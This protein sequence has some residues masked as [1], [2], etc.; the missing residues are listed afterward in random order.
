MARWMLV[1]LM[2]LLGFGQAFA[3]AENSLQIESV[4]PGAIVAIDRIVNDGK[5]IISVSDAG[6]QPVLGLGVADF[7][8]TQDGRKANIIS[9]ES[10]EQNLDVPR[11]IVLVLDNSF[12]MQERNAVKPILAAMDELLKIV[13]PIDQVSLVVF[14]DRETRKVGGRNLHVQILQSSSPSELKGFVKQAY[15]G[16]LTS[17]T[18]LHEGMLAGLD[19]VSRMPEGEPKFMVVFSD[20]E[21]LNSDVSADEVIQASSG[22]KRFAGYAIDYMPGPGVDPLL[23]AFVNRS[24]GQAWKARAESNLV[25]I[26]QAVASRLQY[27]YV[28]SYLFPTLGSLAVA[29]GTVTV[30]EV[31]TIE[32]SP[33]LG[34]VY[35]A[36][37]S[38]EIPGSYL[39]FSDRAGTA[40]FAESMLRGTLEKYR[41]VLNIVG[42][43]MA[44]HPESTIT[45]VGCNANYAEEK[46][47]TQL[48]A[49]RAHEVKVYL[50]TFWGIPGDRIRVEARNLPEQPSTSRIEEGRA[51][52][53]RVEIRSEAPALLDL[54]RSTY[55]D[56]RID[57]TALTLRP[58]VDSVYGIARWHITATA[59]GKGLANIAGEGAPAKEIQVPLTISNLNELATSGDIKVRL[60]LEDLKGQQTTLAA[61]P[62]KVDFIQTRQQMASKQGYQVQETYALVLFDFDSNDV[63]ARNQQIVHQI[64]DRIRALP[65]AT[66]EIVGHTD[67]IG[68]EDYNVKLSERRAKAVYSLL[69]SAYGEDAENRIRYRGVGPFDPLYDNL[70]SETRAF[71]RTVTITLDYLAAE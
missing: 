38:S 37:G 53:R 35:F 44:K 48:S 47:N 71:N 49:A 43:R 56:T 17:K 64:V 12:S 21:D 10:F 26:F 22:T 7:T 19:L 41:H 32:A 59:A 34:H 4:K 27:N 36:T 66:V 9:V 11:H 2:V 60:D 67:N 33:M 46:G 65:Q 16:G 68:K 39:R 40:G 6:K 55:I 30:K 14:S 13:R 5:V 15:S 50:Q 29:P 52:N 42:S 28:A 58:T 24:G 61:E 3:A 63:D 62:V 57:K 8:I 54:I 20:G 51:D 70:S 25:P 18:V 69:M 45:L 1:L 31:K 23:D